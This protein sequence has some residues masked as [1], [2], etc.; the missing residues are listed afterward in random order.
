MKKCSLGLMLFFIMFLSGCGCKHE[1]VEATCTAP[2]TC[3]V[4]GETTGE[5]LTHEWI[6]ATCTDA[7]AC[8]TCGITEGVAL[9]HAWTDATCEKPKTCERCEETDGLALGHTFSE[10]TCTE[11]KTCKLCGMVDG[12]A[13]GHNWAKA[14][15]TKPQRCQVCGLTEGSAAGHDWIPA[16]CTTPKQCNRCSETEGRALGHNRKNGACIV[17]GEKITTDEVLRNMAAFGINQ[18]YQSAKFPSTLHLRSVTYGDQTT[19]GYGDVIRRMVLRFY[20]G[21]AMGGYGDLYV[22]VLCCDHATSYMDQSRNGLYFS[23]NSYSKNPGLEDYYMQN[24]AAM[25]A[26][27]NIINNP[28]DI[29]YD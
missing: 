14:T 7:K 24:S 8:K 13:S 6:E 21:N 26:Y 2:K 9:G 15:C 28:K 5:T 25:H 11:A 22:V 23:T 4:C 16:T 17:C 12:T 19:N 20:A 18:A 27:K 1:W 10:A 29:P 3:S